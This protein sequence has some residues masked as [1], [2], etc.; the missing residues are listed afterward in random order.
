[1][2][3][4]KA[5][6]SVL[7]QTYK[8][9]EIIVVDDGSTDNTSDVLKGYGDKIRYYY[10]LNS[11]VSTARNTGIKAARGE[12]VAF[13]DSDDE[14]KRE[15]LAVQ[16]EQA[17]KYPVAIAHITNAETVVISGERNDHFEETSLARKFRDRSTLFYE[18]PLRTIAKHSP[19]F[20][21]SIVFRKE[22]LLSTRLFDPDLS[23]A[24]DLDVIAQMAMK[25]P[26]TFRNAILVEIYRRKEKMENLGE[27]SKRNYLIRYQSFLKAYENIL[28]SPTLNIS[29]KFT[30]KRIFGIYLRSVGNALILEGKIDSSRP[31]FYKALINFPSIRALIKIVITYIPTRSINILWNNMKSIF[32]NKVD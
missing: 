2:F 30:I 17:K 4:V 8:D 16:M 10:Q 13:L 7:N 1:M 32:G 3:I 14:W 23:I 24:E 22:A 31:F 27:Q 19:W 29:E 28:H 15:Y 12:W 11:G 26:F 20:L 18:R 5:I 21:Q 6:D 25:G 9:F